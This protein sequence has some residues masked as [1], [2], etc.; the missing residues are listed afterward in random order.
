MALMKPFIV[1]KKIKWD[2][3]AKNMQPKLMNFELSF[4]SH[5]NFRDRNNNEMR[6][7]VYENEEDKKNELNK[8]TIN[9]III[10]NK[11]MEYAIKDIKFQI[12]NLKKNSL[13]ESNYNILNNIN[14]NLNLVNEYI[15][16]N[17]KRYFN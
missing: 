5:A 9:E 16:T 11:K 15:F 8:E 6:I 12:E 2:I 17:K 4:Y 10:N 3:Y 13:I 7:Y 14:E 1:P